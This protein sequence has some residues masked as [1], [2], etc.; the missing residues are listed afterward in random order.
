MGR[1]GI[2]YLGSIILSLLFFKYLVVSQVGVMRLIFFF[3]KIKLR[4]F[5]RLLEDK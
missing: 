5:K 1:F 3:F 4:I 2:F